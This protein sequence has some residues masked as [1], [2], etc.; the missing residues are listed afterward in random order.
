VRYNRGIGQEI[1]GE[2]SRDIF[3]N[4]LLKECRKEFFAEGQIFYMYKRLNRNIVG[5][6]GISIPA[7][8]QIFMLPMP[9]DEIAFGQRE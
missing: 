7:S 2:T 8:N 9:N 3:L 5:Q 6:G 1:H 4:E